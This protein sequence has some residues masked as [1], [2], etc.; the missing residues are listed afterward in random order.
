MKFLCDQCKAKYQISDDKVAGKTV[1][2]KCRKCGHLIEVRAAVT[3]SSVA[4][5]IPPPA[6]TAAGG[7]GKPPPAKPSA[8]PKSP[9][10]TSLAQAKPPVPRPPG[11]KPEGGLSTAFKSSVQTRE[12]EAALLELSSADEWYAAINGVPVGPVRVGELRRKAALGA[13]TDDSLVWQEGMEEWRPVK[14]IPEL[15]SLVTRGRDAA[16]FRS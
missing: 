7:P 1:R 16:G 10:A 5:S 6:P 12:D 3:E 11:A 4:A 9:L 14:T 2:M 8:L 13:V 15:A